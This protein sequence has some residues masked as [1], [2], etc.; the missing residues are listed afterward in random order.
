MTGACKT[1]RA[2]IGEG[3]LDRYRVE[4]GFSSMTAAQGAALPWDNQGIAIAMIQASVQA[5]TSAPPLRHEP[6]ALRAAR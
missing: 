1:R 4:F 3:A 5:F 6:S 2:R